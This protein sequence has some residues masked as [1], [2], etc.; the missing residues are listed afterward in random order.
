MRFITGLPMEQEM[1]AHVDAKVC[2]NLRIADG[3]NPICRFG[4]FQH[5]VNGYRVDRSCVPDKA[6][7]EHV[8]DEKLERV[9]LL[10]RTLCIVPLS[11]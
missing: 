8:L 3:L 1:V 10:L 6:R 5:F 11:N 9:G 2:S 4:V 7:A